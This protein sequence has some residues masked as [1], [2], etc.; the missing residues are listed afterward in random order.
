MNKLR[1]WMSGAA[2]IGL[3]DSLYLSWSK[4]ANQ[5]VIC[6]TYKGCETVNASPY[7]EIGGFP[8][9]LLGAGA[10]LS[11]LVLLYLENRND[12]WI[13]NGIL[14]IFVISLA[15]TLYSAY[16]TFIE[17]AVLRAIC[18]YCVVSAIAITAILVLTIIRLVIPQ[19]GT[20]R[21][22]NMESL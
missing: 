17:I 21:I 6:G 12:F 13:Q 15:G 7:A 10:Y 5:Q 20:N 2:V 18:I 16:L 14:G 22:S 1:F 3:L 19:A 4:L 11:I 8:I 9:A